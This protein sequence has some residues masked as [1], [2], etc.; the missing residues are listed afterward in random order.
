MPHTGVQKLDGSAQ[1]PILL[2]ELLPSARVTPSSVL[3]KIG[4]LGCFYRL[5]M[6]RG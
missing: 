3:A 1:N 2:T 4:R 6:R 5:F